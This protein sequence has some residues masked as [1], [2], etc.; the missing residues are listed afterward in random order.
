MVFFDVLIGFCL[1]SGNRR[2]SVIDGFCA[3]YYTT[4]CSCAVY[5]T[6]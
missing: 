3:I 5:A 1:K 6:Q 2:E 4:R